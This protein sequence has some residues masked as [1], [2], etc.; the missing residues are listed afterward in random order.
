MKVKL[1][2]TKKNYKAYLK[3]VAELL[4]MKVKPG[5]PEWEKLETARELIKIYE[6]NK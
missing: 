5:T 2:T 6:E 4:E 3:V 1:I